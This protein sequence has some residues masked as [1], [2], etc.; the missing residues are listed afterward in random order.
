MPLQR[1]SSEGSPSPRSPRSSTDG[2]SGAPLNYN[3][4]KDAWEGLMTQQD[5]SKQRKQMLE[6]MSD[7]AKWA[8]LNQYD[9]PRSLE[10][11]HCVT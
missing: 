11:A 1:K 7:E 4:F 8:L 9:A 6:G 3:Q 2:G 5:F 10:C